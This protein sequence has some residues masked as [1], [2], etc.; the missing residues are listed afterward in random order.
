MYLSATSMGQY[1]PIDSPVHR[2]DPR[3]KLLGLV[4]LVSAVFASSDPLSLGICILALF[5]IVFLS[6]LPWRTIL[7]SS[8]PI[9]FLVAFTL[10][11]NVVSELW[12]G[13]SLGGSLARGGLTALRLMVLMLFAVLLP[14]TTAPLELADGLERLLRPLARFGFPSHECAM[15]T[16]V[17]LRFIPLL[18]EETDRIIRAQ[19]SRGA[20]LDQGGIVRRVMAF[21]P[22]LIPLFVI[23][24]RRAD[25]MALAMEARGYRGGEGRTKR[26]PLCWKKSDTGATICTV[27]FV[28]LLLLLRRFWL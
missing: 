3:A 6:G 15:M 11:F 2:L 22:V 5:G 1:V 13:R 8:R 17:A 10:V 20:R 7:R 27:C 19:L 23:V 18:M 25:E 16:G 21:F 24:F 28:V 14:L 26:R 12:M 9:L 4:L